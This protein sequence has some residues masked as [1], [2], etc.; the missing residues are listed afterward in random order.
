MAVRLSSTRPARAWASQ[1]AK[2]RTPRPASSR[3]RRLTSS[4]AGLGLLG[5][6]GA[7]GEGMTGLPPQPKR[8]GRPTCLA[9]VLEPEFPAGGWVAGLLIDGQP[10]RARSEQAPVLVRCS[11]MVEQAAC[12]AF[13][14]VGGLRWWA[15][16]LGSSLKIQKAAN[17]SRRHRACPSARFKLSARA[18]RRE[19]DAVADSGHGDARSRPARGHGGPQASEAH[20]RASAL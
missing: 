2:P 15:L 16:P 13:E 5:L 6:S 11:R 18:M 3:H 4:G 8:Q 19:S 17:S 9:S 1:R 10:A 20:P 14:G 12:L 7:D